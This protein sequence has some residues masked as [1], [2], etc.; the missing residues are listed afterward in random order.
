MREPKLQADETGAWDSS[1]R[2]SRMSEARTGRGDCVPRLETATAANRLACRARRHR[3]ATIRAAHDLT[4]PQA[5]LVPVD[6]LHDAAIA[7]ALPRPDADF[8]SYRSSRT[9]GAGPA[10]Q[11][12]KLGVTLAFGGFKRSPRAP[13]ADVEICARRNQQLRDLHP[14][15]DGPFGQWRSPAGRCGIRIGARRDEHAHCIPLSGSHRL[16]ERTVAIAV[17]LVWIGADV[18]ERSQLCQ[19]AFARGF[20]KRRVR[21][22]RRARRLTQGATDH[23]ECRHSGPNDADRG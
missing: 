10:Q 8:V 1:L 3:G 14:S 17:A 13:I 4:D 15:P 23:Q 18:E 16:Y 7:V 19:I 11:G 9:A 21:R 5:I 20:M 22:G 6:G 12:C 2:H